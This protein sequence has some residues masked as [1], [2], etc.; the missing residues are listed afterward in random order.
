[1]NAKDTE[2][3]EQ[4]AELASVHA[5]LSLCQDLLGEWVV[6]GDLSFSATHRDAT[7]EDTFAILMKLPPD[8]PNSHPKVQE[9]GG[10]IPT[11]F[12]QFPDRTLCLGAPAEVQVRFTRAPR[13]L[14]FVNDLVIPYLFSFRYWQDHREMPF[15]ELS[16]GGRGILE[17]YQDL[18]CI[19]D[20]SAILGLLKIL[21]DNTYR[22]HLR[23]P[24]GSGQVL[25]RCHGTQLRD[26][27][28]VQS[29]ESFL[30]EML[31]ILNSLGKEEI[32]K[33]SR[34]SLPNRLL[35]KSERTGHPLNSAD[36]GLCQASEVRATIGSN[37][38]PTHFYCRGTAFYRSSSGNRT[39]P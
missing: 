14:P 27:M 33:L 3:Q 2:I 6:R 1:M 25:R 15:G 8:F 34:K 28:P 13:L 36:A 24:C 12:H 29:R 26:L 4:F 9:T 37:R 19:E 22:G 18:F 11:D 23:C 35:R 10:R 38:P 16:H 39:T 32:R 7:I 20:H 21:A 31:A 17:Y 30:A 5:G